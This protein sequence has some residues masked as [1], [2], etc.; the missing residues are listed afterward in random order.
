MLKTVEFFEPGLKMRCTIGEP[1]PQGLKAFRIHYRLFGQ[2]LSL[3]QRGY[4][5]GQAALSAETMC[6]PEA[7][8]FHVCEEA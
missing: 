8:I 6:F 7:R 3:V 4:N 5:A 1:K 2:E